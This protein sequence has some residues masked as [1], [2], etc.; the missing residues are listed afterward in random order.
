MKLFEP[1]NIGALRVKNRIVMAPMGILGLFDTDGG[2]LPRAIEYYERRAAGGA[3][4]IITSLFYTSREIEQIDDKGMSSAPRADSFFYVSRFSE[5]ADAV[6]HHG[7]KI[8]VQLTAGMGRVLPHFFFREHPPVAPSPLPCFWKPSV[9]TRALTTEEVERLVQSFALAAMLLRTAGMDAVELHGHEGYLMDQFTTA[10]WNQRADKYGGSLEGRLRFPLEIIRAIKNFVGKD[11]P[12]I[13]RYSVTHYLPGGREIE[14][15]LQMAKILKQAGVDAFHVDAGCYES[16]HWAHPPTYQPPGCLV[17]MA[18]AIKKVVDTPVI[19]VG[20]LGYPEL[21]EKVLREGKAD[22]IAMGR[23]LLADPDWA[24]KVRERRPEDIIPCIGDHDGCLGRVL[25]GKYVSCTVNP[26]TGMEKRYA[27]Q[28]ATQ[29]KSV[30]VI[31]SG[32]G[33]M[34][35]ARVAALRGH[36]VTLWEKG[37]Q[38]GGNLIAAS[39][40]DF[41]ADL[42]LLL[43]Y[44]R[45]QLKKLKIRVELGKMATASAVEKMK[46]QVVIVATGSSHSVPDIP[47]A[48]G[49][50][51]VTA[52]EALLGHKAIGDRV[53]VIGVGLIGCETALFLAQQRKQVTLV[54]RRDA[55]AEDVFHANRQM[56]LLL[57]SQNKVEIKTGFPLASIGAQGVL[58]WGDEEL[59]AD[60]VVLATGLKSESG[61]LRELK[62]RVPE[63]YAIG[64]CV[65]PR[66]IIDAIWEGFHASRLL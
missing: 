58:G 35:A 46:P 22:F 53:I 9:T 61:L 30:L 60:S 42:R 62:G 20:K 38:L 25:T 63:L 29:R 10:L 48:Q 66:K 33:G 51:V 15:S 45:T 1:G 49:N 32:P 6:H 26:Q 2:L 39:V 31:G 16:F 28:P 55:L 4:L 43:E 59:R 21:A 24:N 19:A 50:N 13:Y 17:N 40:P 64:D 5:L 36:K 27:L 54:A 23:S 14:E 57:L 47:G 18:E 3:G 44:L 12:V 11:F 7:C 8:A 41:K 34:E 37:D 52:T 56:L 65:M